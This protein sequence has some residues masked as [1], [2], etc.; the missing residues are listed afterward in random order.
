MQRSGA[1]GVM[2]S[3]SGRA[4]DSVHA[5]ILLGIF[6]RLTFTKL[7]SLVNVILFSHDH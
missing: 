2:V 4:R 1:D 5:T 6:A 3:P 7:S